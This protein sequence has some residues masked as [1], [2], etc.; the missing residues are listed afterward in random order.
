MCAL[1]ALSSFPGWARPQMGH[2]QQEEGDGR[3]VLVLASRLSSALRLLRMGEL[4]ADSPSSSESWSSWLSC[5]SS[6]ISSSRSSRAASSNSPSGHTSH[7]SS[8][9]PVTVLLAERGFWDSPALDNSPVPK[10]SIPPFFVLTRLVHRKPIK[11]SFIPGISRSSLAIM[12][13][14]YV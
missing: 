2:D 12:G 8:L 5:S 1:N 14:A 4:T 7:S 6:F 9:S 13:S 3:Q 10:K 11:R